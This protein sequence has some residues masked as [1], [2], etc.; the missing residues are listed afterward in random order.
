[1]YQKK[2][3][4]GGEKSSRHN[5]IPQVAFS[6]LRHHRRWSPYCTIAHIK[7]TTV[8]PNSLGVYDTRKPPAALRTV[9][10]HPVTFLVAGR[11]DPHRLCTP[12]AA[13]LQHIKCSCIASQ[14]QHRWAATTQLPSVYKSSPSMH[15]CPPANPIQRYSL[16]STRCPPSPY[17]A[18]LF[19]Q[20]TPE[21]GRQRP[22][23]SNLSMLFSAGA[24]AHSQD[25]TALC[26]LYRT[27]FSTCRAAQIT[28][29]AAL[30]SG[31]RD[32]TSRKKRAA[33]EII[34]YYA[35]ESS[36][37]THEIEYCL[38]SLPAALPAAEGGLPRLD[39][40]EAPRLAQQIGGQRQS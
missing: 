12:M 19:A 7:Q 10:R 20:V 33:S 13:T 25:H 38:Q 3:K 14:R 4:K 34:M 28:S 17:D 22:S 1:M 37:P 24:C 30:T 16:S 36:R 26:R 5:A 15:R 40:N 2:K 32:M 29:G 27:A 8:S 11:R 18:S 6:R 35:W 21:V 9:D 39:S 31:G 23:S